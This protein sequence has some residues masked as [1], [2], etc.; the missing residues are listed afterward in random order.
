MNGSEEKENNEHVYE[1][2]NKWHTRI[3]N[4]LKFSV[5]IRVA[6]CSGWSNG[7]WIN[8]ISSSYINYF[9]L[10]SDINLHV[11]CFIHYK[12]TSKIIQIKLDIGSTWK[13]DTKKN[14]RIIE[15]K[16]V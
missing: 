1:K 10:H 16:K 11:T 7:I 2:M 8:A 3:H 14:I 9:Y 13:Q 12:T 5:R 15:V 4:F 6:G